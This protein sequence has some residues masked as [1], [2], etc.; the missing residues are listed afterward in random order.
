MDL[1][2]VCVYY[3]YWN[4]FV[5]RCRLP[6]V[7]E[8]DE[9]CNLWPIE[10]EL[11]FGLPEHFTDFGL[12]DS[13]RHR[14]LG[15]AWSVHV[16]GKILKPLVSQYRSCHSNNPH[17]MLLWFGVQTNVNII[18]RLVCITYGLDSLIIDTQK[19][20]YIHLVEDNL[21]LTKVD[22]HTS[23]QVIILPTVSTNH[24]WACWCKLVVPKR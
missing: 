23:P 15:K 7:L 10:L 1:V 21:W 18:D 3:I 4:L 19:Q 14:L 12:C 17:W 16:I 9:L 20:K 22:P 6:P 13:R 11:L 8:E 2:Y 24:G 5:G